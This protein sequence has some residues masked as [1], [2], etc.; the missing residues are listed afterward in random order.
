M[1]TGSIVLGTTREI[2]GVIPSRKMFTF[3]LLCANL[4]ANTTINLQFSL[5]KTNWSN[6]QEGGTDITFTLVDDTALA[7][8]VA[9]DAGIYFRLLFAGVTTGTVAYIHNGL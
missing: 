1:K 6:A 2:I 7:V 8:P 4:S 3:Q 9:A 5:D